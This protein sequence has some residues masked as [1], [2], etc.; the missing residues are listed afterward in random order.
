MSR[1]RHPASSSTTAA[2]MP[3]AQLERWL[4]DR[5][6]RRP[7]ATSLPMLDGYVAAIVAGPVSISPLDW[8]CPLLAIDADAFNHGGT[9]GVRGDLRRRAAPQRHQQHPLD[10]PE[11][12]RADPS[13][14]AERRRRRASMVPGIPRRHAAATIGLG[15]AARHPQRQ[16]RPAAAHPAALSWT[17]RAVR[18]S[19]RQGKVPRPRNFCATPTP[20]SQRSS[21]PC[22]STGCRSATPAPA[23]YRLR[24]C[25]YRLRRNGEKS[26]I[27]PSIAE[28][29]VFLEQKFLLVRLVER[30]GSLKE[31]S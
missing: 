17:I 13:A 24:G 4:Q 14:Q 10:Q 1:R 30:R 9:A 5:A 19:D 27:L 18:C 6:E 23:D 12:V 2:A 3:L 29:T 15:A 22:A 25:S 31:A 20:I 16:P 8:I 28:T 11:A 26:N 7:V 21:R